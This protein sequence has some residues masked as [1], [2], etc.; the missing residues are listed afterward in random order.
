MGLAH[1]MWPKH[2]PEPHLESMVEAF[3]INRE[4]AARIFT[5]GTSYYQ[6]G[7]SP[8]QPEQVADA[9]DALCDA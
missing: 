1:R 5:T 2:V 3:G 7:Y 8:V 9:I 6:S 4:A